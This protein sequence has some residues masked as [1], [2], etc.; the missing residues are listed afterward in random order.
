MTT[1]TTLKSKVEHPGAK[2]MMMRLRRGAG[3][4]LEQHRF[5]QKDDPQAVTDD[6]FAK[7]LEAW[8]QVEAVFRCS[9]YTGCI[10]GEARC[11]PDAPVVCEACKSPGEGEVTP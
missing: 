4:L 11:S 8:D 2:P 5:W 7:V 9:G 10:W 6:E 1:S 3:W